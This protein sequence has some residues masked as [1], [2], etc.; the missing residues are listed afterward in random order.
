MNRKIV[1]CLTVCLVI[2]FAGTVA[3]AESMMSDNDKGMMMASEK[4]V[5][6]AADNF[7]KMTPANGFFRVAVRDLKMKWESAS[8]KGSMQDFVIVDVR[9]PKDFAVEHI[10]MAVNV[11]L[12]T[13]IDKLGM[14]SKDKPI[15]VV[16]ALDSNSSYATAVLRMLGYDAYMVPGGEGA[17]KMAGYPLTSGM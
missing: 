16:C 6:M 17:W 8:M 4:N 9:G 15:Y 10:P 2:V 7:L 12:P 11:P 14:I 13:L 5:M 3:F 1:V